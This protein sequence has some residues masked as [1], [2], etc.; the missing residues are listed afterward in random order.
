MRY[1]D[2]EVAYWLAHAWIRSGWKL[3]D[4]PNVIA[5]VRTESALNPLLWLVGLT[6]LAAVSAGAF[7]RD[8]LMWALIYAMAAEVA[9]AL[10]AYLYFMLRDPNR[11]HSERYQ[12]ERQ[13]MELMLDERYP[14]R[15]PV[16][17]DV[18]PTSNTGGQSSSGSSSAGPAE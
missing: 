9:V 2:R 12:L 14:G 3:P 1:P 8:D 5:R 13:R 11:L 18:T 15:L 6:L 10:L 17:I 7:D 4:L 16:T